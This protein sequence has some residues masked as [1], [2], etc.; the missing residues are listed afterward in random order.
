M[1]HTAV[2][3][4]R[5]P[6]GPMVAAIMRVKPEQSRF[7]WWREDVMRM[8]QKELARALDISPT[9]IRDYER[10]DPIP[11]KVR[12]ACAALQLGAVFDFV[13]LTMSPGSR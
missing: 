7:R 4:G 6:P 11:V 3:T 10:G 13:D 12:L 1:T 8:T 2:N 9:R 5:Q